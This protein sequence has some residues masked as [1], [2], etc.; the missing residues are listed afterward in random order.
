MLDFD[1]TGA[2]AQLVERSVR[3]AEVE[4]ST[5]FCSTRQKRLKTAKT[6]WKFGVFLFNLL[7]GT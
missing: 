7:G 2:V 5:P 3:N 6:L 4:G 1:Q